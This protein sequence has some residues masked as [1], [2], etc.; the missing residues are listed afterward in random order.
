MALHLYISASVCLLAVVLGVKGTSGVP[1]P[2]NTE[3]NKTITCH[4]GVTVP[5]TPGCSNRFLIGGKP[6]A[7]VEGAEAKF[8]WPFQFLAA[9]GQMKVLT[10]VDFTHES[11]CDVGA[12]HLRDIVTYYY[13]AKD[14]SPGAATVLQGPPL[15]LLFAVVLMMMLKA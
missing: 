7:K 4:G 3:V 13:M 8:L 6:L 5:I 10:C 1:G 9:E 12:N 14:S 15:F 2:G 11:S